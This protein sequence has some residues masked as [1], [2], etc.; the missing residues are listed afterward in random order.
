MDPHAV[1]GVAPGASP[2]DIKKAY[3]KLAVKH[4]PD[5]G[6]DAEKFKQVAAA[7]EALTNPQPSPEA[8][9]PDIFASMFGRAGGPVRRNDHEHTIGISLA[10]AFTGSKKHIKVSVDRPC[11]GCTAQCRACQGHGR[12]NVHRDMGPFAQMFAMPCE[13]C[14]GTGSVRNGCPQCSFKK[15]RTETVNLAIQIPVGVETGHA[16]RMKGL[17][18]QAQA[19]NDM[20]GDLII[21]IEVAGHP[22]FLRYG[23]DL[24]YTKRVSFD[25]SVRGV[26]FSVP[27]FAGPVE[28]DSAKFGILDPRRDYVVSGKGMVGGDLRISF[29]V[30]YPPYGS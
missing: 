10:E 7:Y 1:L 16:F 28:V 4:H 2:E 8:S 20:A 26:V 18:E 19:E 17:G 13:A 14:A 25:E 23:K 29:D 24:V 11:T 9:L 6:G 5:K 15:A 12:V 22:E 21:K 30:Q 3:R 27:H